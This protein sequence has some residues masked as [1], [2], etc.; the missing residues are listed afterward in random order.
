VPTLKLRYIGALQ[1]ADVPILG[2]EG[3]DPLEEHGAGC[4]VR[5]EEFDCD[6]TIAGRA[7]K[8]DADG[9]LE[10]GDDGQPVDLGEGLLAQLGNFEL[11][12]T[13]RKKRAKKTA[14]PRKTPTAASPPAPPA[15]ATTDN[16]KPEA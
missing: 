4:V 15:D 13:P 16:D 14:A 6:A 8:L 2:R 7:P 12:S 10:L 9:A 5:G 1:Y 11:A 3:D